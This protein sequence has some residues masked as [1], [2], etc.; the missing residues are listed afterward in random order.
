L[1]IVSVIEHLKEDGNNDDLLEGNN[2]KAGNSDDEGE[3]IR[4]GEMVGTGVVTTKFENST[5]SEFRLEPHHDAK[6]KPTSS[7]P[8]IPI[9][10]SPI[11]IKFS[12][13]FGL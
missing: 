12:L 10:F 8:S 4:K 3:I 2:D 11:K 7:D 9:V 13:S 1:N 5:F 6:P